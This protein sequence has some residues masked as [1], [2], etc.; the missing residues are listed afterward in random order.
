ML[1]I[2][3]HVNLKI[4][5]DVLGKSSK[6][7]LTEF[8]LFLAQRSVN[9]SQV[10]VKTGISKTRMT[11]LTTQAN[12]HL[13]VSELYLVSLAID[14]DPCEMLKFLSKDLKLKL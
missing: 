2:S 12:S 9:K 7:T 8:G 1:K 3:C 14:A 11:R 5:N 4:N 10:S 13:R 6:S